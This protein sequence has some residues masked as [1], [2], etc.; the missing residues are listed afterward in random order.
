[1]M[2][3]MIPCIEHSRVIVFLSPIWGRTFNRER[4][5]SMW[6]TFMKLGHQQ[7]LWTGWF[8][9]ELSVTR[10]PTKAGAWKPECCTLIP[11]S[12][13][14]RWWQV[15]HLFWCLVSLSCLVG[16]IFICIPSDC[17]FAETCTCPNLLSDLMP[18]ISITYSYHLSHG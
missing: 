11:L 6:D 16:C 3:L 15:P 13:Y 10:H 12:N 7:L 4:A 1:M 5:H 18:W 8:A 17:H 2:P 14:S 9:V